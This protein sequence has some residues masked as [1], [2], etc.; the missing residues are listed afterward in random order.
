M[1]FQANG[2]LCNFQSSQKTTCLNAGM[3]KSATLAEWRASVALKEH[4]KRGRS[5]AEKKV[6]DLGEFL[7]K[8]QHAAVCEGQKNGPS[9]TMETVMAQQQWQR[10]DPI[11][12][13]VV[14]G[15]MLQKEGWVTVKKGKLFETGLLS[16]KEC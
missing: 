12:C 9:N 5:T 10:T 15:G 7:C 2:V 1:H 8:A 14:G 6:R 3:L 4:S 11:W 13:E 16:A